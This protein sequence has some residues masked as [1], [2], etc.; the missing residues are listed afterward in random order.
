MQQ[1]ELD[2]ILSGNENA[3]TDRQTAADVGR[4]NSQGKES[5]KA[6][7]RNERNIL[8]KAAYCHIQW[9]QG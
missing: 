1:L 2:N 5:I 7:G 9:R 8:Q 6:C 4:E 3:L